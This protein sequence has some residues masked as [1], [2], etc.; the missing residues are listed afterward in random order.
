[1]ARLIFAMVAVV[2]LLTSCSGGDDPPTSTLGGTL[3]PASASV[4][5]SV[6]PADDADIAV[7]SPENGSTVRGSTVRIE[8]EVSEFELVDK[9]GEKAAPGEGHIVFYMGENYTVPTALGEPANRGGAG[10]FTSYMGADTSYTWEN[11]SPGRITFRVQL[12][13]NDNTPLDPPQVE[14]TTVT[15]EGT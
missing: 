15:V 13:N 14:E 6:L 10:V 11:V 8:T 5:P 4:K 3:P 12:V 2:S 7:V 1:M 9:I